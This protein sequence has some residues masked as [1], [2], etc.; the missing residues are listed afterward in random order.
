MTDLNQPWQK[1]LIAKSKCKKAQAKSLRNS[2]KLDETMANKQNNLLSLRGWQSGEISRS[3]WVVIL[4]V[5]LTFLFS[6]NTY[7]QNPM[8]IQTRQNGPLRCLADQFLKIHTSKHEVPRVSL[9]RPAHAPGRKA[10]RISFIFFLH[11][12]S[13]REYNYRSTNQKQFW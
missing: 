5:M 3:Q 11:A 8:L 12:N 13:A 7:S 10:V 1:I 6:V 2:R 4:M 9:D